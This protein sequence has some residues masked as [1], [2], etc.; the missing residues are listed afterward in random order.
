MHFVC[1]YV[2]EF[3]AIKPYS[4]QKPADNKYGRVVTL[5]GFGIFGSRLNYLK[6]RKK[7][8]CLES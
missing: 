5:L 7:M 4:H 2:N 3:R 6:G 8:G 1:I